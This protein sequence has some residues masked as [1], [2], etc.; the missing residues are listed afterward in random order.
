MTTAIAR[1]AQN[2]G[3]WSA[4]I[5]WPFGYRFVS[6]LS[7]ADLFARIDAVQR[8]LGRRVATDQVSVFVA[9]CAAIAEG[10]L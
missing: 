3:I 9:S 6:A 4:M 8:G 2:H 7:R 5:E 1:V 10:R